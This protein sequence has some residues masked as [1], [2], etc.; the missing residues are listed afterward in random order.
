MSDE[1]VYFCL[2]HHDRYDENWYLRDQETAIDA[3]LA[4]DLVR[5]MESIDL[6]RAIDCTIDTNI[7]L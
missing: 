2:E 3:V 6:C 4:L 1:C 7:I 5:V